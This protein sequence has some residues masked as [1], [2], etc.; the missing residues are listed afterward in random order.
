MPL[1]FGNLRQTVG[2]YFST[3][4]P[5]IVKTTRFSDDYEER[6]PDNILSAEEMKQ[7]QDTMSEYDA[8]V[9]VIFVRER[10]GFGRRFCAKVFLFTNRFDKFVVK[11]VS[12]FTSK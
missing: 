1:V 11:I 9:L 6:E 8:F 5:T 10:H 4:Y 2:E 3:I 12:R 7:Q